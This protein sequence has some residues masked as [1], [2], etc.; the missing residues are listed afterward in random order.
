MNIFFSAIKSLL[1]SSLNFDNWKMP[2]KKEIL[3]YDA[4]RTKIIEKYLDKKNYHIL[5]I[6][7]IEN[8]KFNF[9][10]IFKL[11]L[12]LKLS[13][14]NYKLEYIKYVSPKFVLSMI[15]TNYGFYRLKKFF[16]NVKFILIQFAWRHN[17]VDSIPAEE[18]NSEGVIKN[19]IDFFLVFNEYIKKEFQKILKAEYLVF[20]SISSNSFAIKKNNIEYKYLLIGQNTNEKQK[21]VVLKEGITLEK[22]LQPDRD[23]CKALTKFIKH[24][25]KDKLFILGKSWDSEEAIELYDKLLGRENYT[26]IPRKPGY[27][28]GVIDKA[29]FIFGTTS[30]LLYEGLSRRKR[31]GVFNNKS[32]EKI[33]EKTTFGWPAVM[34]STGPFWT[35]NIDVN[36]IKRI[37]NFLET[38]KDNDWEDLLKEKFDHLLKYDENNSKFLNFAKKINLPVKNLIREYE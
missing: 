16:P 20:G 21:N 9:F 33:Y 4:A 30:T 22:F 35:N 2:P 8:Y 25:K 32:K 23:M 6:R 13:P 15:D 3:I 31:V 11:I 34:S 5:H 38:V 17:I 7:Y 26:Y 37:I 18:I 12:S 19:N 14:K 10:I 24:E 28:Y 27:S 1:I 36:E 29:E